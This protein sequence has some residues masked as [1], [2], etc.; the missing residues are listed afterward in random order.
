MVASSSG[1]IQKSIRVQAFQY[2]VEREKLR[3]GSHGGAQ[4][5][6]GVLPVTPAK[7]NFR[8]I[9]R[10]AT[11]EERRPPAPHR[12]ETGTLGKTTA[13]AIGARRLRR[14]ELVA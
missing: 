9:L 4:Y 2:D 1:S 14:R 6:D 11:S 7:E 3:Q 12:Y 5:D 10:L 8:K 13:G